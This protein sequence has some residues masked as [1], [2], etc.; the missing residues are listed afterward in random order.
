MSLMKPARR[1]RKHPTRRSAGRPNRNAPNGG[2][3]LTDI[4]IADSVGG[5]RRNLRQ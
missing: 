1:N 3:S 4:F 2:A 5:I